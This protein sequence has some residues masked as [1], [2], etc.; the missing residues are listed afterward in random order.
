MKNQ[1]IGRQGEDIACLFLK[2]RGYRILER[3]YRY[4]SNELDIIAE[5]LGVL[6]VVEVKTRSSTKYGKPLEAI[7]PYKIE[8]I[9]NAT[10]GYIFEKKL[11]G[12]QVRFDIIEV[13]D[14]SINH[15]EDGFNLR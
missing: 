13:L 3:N 14:G 10:Y 4:K 15:I 11:D 8:G 6:V 12:V 5:H 2:E 1:L 9:V 7:S